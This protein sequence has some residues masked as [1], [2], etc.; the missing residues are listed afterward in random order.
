[1]LIFTSPEYGILRVELGLEVLIN[2]PLVLLLPT[3]IIAPRSKAA[4]QRR[5]DGNSILQRL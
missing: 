2:F 1:M 3:A 4:N 5:K